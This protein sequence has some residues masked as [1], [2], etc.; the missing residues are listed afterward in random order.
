[1]HYQLQVPVAARDP[2]GRTS[3]Y[4]PTIT[5]VGSVGLHLYACPNVNYGVSAQM[6]QFYVAVYIQPWRYDSA[7]F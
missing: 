3:V 7:T 2:A 1:M 6:G 5:T 4:R